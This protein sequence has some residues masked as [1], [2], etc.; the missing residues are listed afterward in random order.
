M[1]LVFILIVFLI[2]AVLLYSSV[3]YTHMPLTGD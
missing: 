3:Q 1:D 2:A